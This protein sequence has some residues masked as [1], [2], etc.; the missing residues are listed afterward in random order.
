MVFSSIIFLF[1]FLPVVLVGYVLTPRSMR[2]LF[3]LITSLFFYAWGEGRYVLLMLFIVTI[4]YLAGMLMDRLKGQTKKMLLAAALFINL[5]PLLYFKYALFLATTFNNLT[6]GSEL[7]KVPE[8]AVHLPLGISF[9]TFQAISYLV[10]VYRT[11]S[12]PQTNP[13]NLG[14]YI[15]LFPQLIAGPIVRYHDIARQ[16]LERKVDIQRF[17]SGVE[18]FIIGLGKKTLLANNLGLIAELV[19]TL[20]A[21]QLTPASVWIGAVCYSLQIY[22]DFSGYSDMAIGLGRMFGFTFLENFN[23]PYISRSIRE[24]WQRWHI[25]LSNWFRDYIYIP[26]GGNRGSSLQTMRNLI[27]V[28][29]LCGLWH[30]A[31]W[32]FVFWGAYHGFFLACERGRFGRLLASLPVILRHGYTLLVVMI[33][34]IFFRAETFTQAAHMVKT[35]CGFSAGSGIPYKLLLHLDPLF[36]T[37]VFLGIAGMMPVFSGIRKLLSLKGL[38]SSNMINWIEPGTRLIYLS[39]VLILSMA[40]LAT[41]VYNPFIYFRF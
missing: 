4:N 29:L 37:A 9:F 1:Q 15:A 19:L 3:L 27:T 22:Y 38:Q 31:S 2:N 32:T 18:R 24:F 5:L 41:G 25:S 34:W 23:Y 16:L 13:F 39:L 8:V 10:D 12:P 40:S 7:P 36:Y 30:G 35:L 33:G 14:L 6:S 17:A 28:F 11:T 26:L 20:P 21:D